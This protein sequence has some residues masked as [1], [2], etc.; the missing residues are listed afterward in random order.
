MNYTK[1]L[2]EYRELQ[3]ALLKE[4]GYVSDEAY[5]FDD[6][7]IEDRQDDFK[8]FLEFLKAKQLGDIVINVGEIGLKLR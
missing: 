4:M 5:F 3:K 6:T 7:C 1:D 2:A 8:C